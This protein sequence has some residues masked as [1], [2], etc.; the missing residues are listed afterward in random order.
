MKPQA[1]STDVQAT[2]AAAQAV[3]RAGL[4]AFATPSRFIRPLC[5]AAI[6]ESRPLLNEPATPSRFRTP[7]SP[8]SAQERAQDPSRFYAPHW[9]A[10]RGSARPLLAGHRTRSGY[11]HRV[12]QGAAASTQIT[13][14]GSPRVPRAPNTGPPRSRGAACSPK[15]TLR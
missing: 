8:Q 3:G 4:S 6:D 9:V 14:F 1:S 10:L 15:E 7:R 13:A 2:A 5:T 12:A 11:E